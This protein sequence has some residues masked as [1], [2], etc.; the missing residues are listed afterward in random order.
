MQE[1]IADEFIKKTIERFSKTTYGPGLGGTFD[2]AS[3]PGHGATATL[4]RL[5]TDA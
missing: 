4:N 5:T 3:T 2:I 1:G